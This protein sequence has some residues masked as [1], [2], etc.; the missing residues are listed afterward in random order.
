MK[1]TF[2]LEGLKNQ[3][4]SMPFEFYLL[5]QSQNMPTKEPLGKLGFTP[6]SMRDQMG[7]MKQLA[8]ND[9]PSTISLELHHSAEAR[10]EFI[11]FGGYN[12]T[13]MLDQDNIKWYRSYNQRNW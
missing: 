13:V 5:T 12:S 9:V 7:I 6:N 11:T 3:N 1:D 8:E 4:I 10:M 2:L